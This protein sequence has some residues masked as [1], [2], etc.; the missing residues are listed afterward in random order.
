MH[1]G[2]HLLLAGRHVPDHCGRGDTVQKWWYVEK[3]VSYLPFL[4]ASST[5]GF[6]SLDRQEN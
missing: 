5:I 1:P 6:V 2:G 4:A 3:P